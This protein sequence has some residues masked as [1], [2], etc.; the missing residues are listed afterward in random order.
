MFKTFLA[1]GLKQNFEKV[2]IR[3]TPDNKSF[4][5]MLDNFALKPEALLNTY[6]ECKETG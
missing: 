6:V 5:K 3:F 1:E 2:I 4:A